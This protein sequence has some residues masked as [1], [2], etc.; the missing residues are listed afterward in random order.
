MSLPNATYVD[1]FV[2]E[3]LSE[4]IKLDNFYS[5]QLV[6]NV[7]KDHIFRIP[8]DDFFLKYKTQLEQITILYSMPESSFYKPKQV[9][10]E[11]YGT[12]EVWLGL[13]RLN[14]MR[15]ITEF[16]RPIIKVYNPYQLNELIDIFFKRDGIIS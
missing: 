7:N 12:T 4:T 2:S 9:S 13:L 1:Q 14:N 6:A 5:T 11:L 16:H 10:Y 15:N 3:G 8:W